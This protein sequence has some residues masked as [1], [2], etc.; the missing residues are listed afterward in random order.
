MRRS[1]RLVA[2]LS[3]LTPGART[4]RR[5]R[6]WRGRP[7]ARRWPPRAT[8]LLHPSAV[9]PRARSPARSTA[10]RTSSP[11]TTGSLGYGEGYATAETSICNL[12]DTVLTARGQRSRYLGADARYN[13]HVTLD[14]TN[15]QTR[16]AVH[17]HPQPQGG[18]EAARRPEAPAPARQTRALV[19][20]YA[21]G[22]NHY[23]RDV[24]GA[25]GRHR[26]GLPRRRGCGPNATANDIW[27]A[28]YAA[29]LLASTGRVRAADRRRRAAGRRPTDGL[30]QAPVRRRFAARDPDRPAAAKELLKAALGKD[31]R[32]AV[33][34]QRHRR[35]LR[36]PPPPA[37]G[38]VLGNPH[39]PWR[40][41]YR[42]TQFH[43][44]IPGKYNVA[45]AG[46]IGSPVVNI[47]WNKNVA[48][49]HTVSTAYRFTPYEYKS[50]PA[51]APRYLTEN[52]PTAAGEAAP[53]GSRSSGPTARCS[54]VT[55]TVYRTDEGYVLDAPDALMPWSPTSVF[56][57]RDANAE[58]LRTLDTFH[59][60]GQGPQRARTCSPP[61]TAAPG[62]PG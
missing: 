22:V 20:G 10:S 27:Y 53:S 47:G 1:H 31:P 3:A 24:G 56:A 50:C 46:L 44:T 45:G 32:L 13:D 57:L 38:M 14:A 21:A 40:G 26:P 35:R 16:H 12:A 48:W 25:K 4:G 34:L 41:R 19:R 49:S 37:A 17:R 23:L 18:R 59:N 52:G 39:F 58:Q 11:T 2:A 30:P 7:P 8:S 28:V 62:C 29:N 54:T 43:L 55:R 61:R 5:C 42:F 51:P 6:P 33:R 15:L 36:T 9:V 60:Y